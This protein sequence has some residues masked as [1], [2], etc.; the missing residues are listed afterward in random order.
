MT[1]LHMFPGMKTKA[2]KESRD[3]WSTR[4]D[5][6]LERMLRK[7]AERRGLTRKGDILRSFV[8]EKLAGDSD[9]RMRAV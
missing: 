5:K 1:Q 4:L 7:W 8:S 3:V 6:P 2:E 9:N